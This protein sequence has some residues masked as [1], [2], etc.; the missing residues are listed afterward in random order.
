MKTKLLRCLFNACAILAVCLMATISTTKAE[1]FVLKSGESFEGT[2]IRSLGNTVSIKLAGGGM[3]QVPMSEVL[4]VKFAVQGGEPISGTL[5]A[6]SDG[7][8]EI[9]RGDRLIKVREGRVL[10][11]KTPAGASPPPS[12]I[13]VTA[14]QGTE[15]GGEMKFTVGFSAPTQKPILLIFSTSDLTAKAGSD[16]EE[17]RGALKVKPGATSAVVRVPLMDDQLSEG[18]ESF[19]LLVTTDL[20]VAK[21]E[22]QRATATILDND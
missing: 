18:N 2:V 17:V 22:V 15:N 1:T 20:D 5:Y 6:W 11:A 10:S 7:T 12:K 21:V 3:R 16:Y 9:R 4:K 19:E 8:Y 13:S 14:T